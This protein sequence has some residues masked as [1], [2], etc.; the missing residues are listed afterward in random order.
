MSFVSYSYTKQE[1]DFSGLCSPVELKLDK[2]PTKSLAGRYITC[3]NDKSVLLDESVH[4]FAV[5]CT[6]LE[7]VNRK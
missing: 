4:E 6:V 7:G 5:D 1:L 2:G 3:Y